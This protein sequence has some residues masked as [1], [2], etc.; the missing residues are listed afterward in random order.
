MH[1]T[2][3]RPIKLR[4]KDVSQPRLQ[5][6]LNE[7]HC[8]LILSFRTAAPDRNHQSSLFWPSKPLK[9]HPTPLAHWASLNFQPDAMASLL[10]PPDAVGNPMATP[11]A[12]QSGWATKKDWIKHQALIG[13]LY[14][15]QPLAEVMEFMES[16]HGF[17]A[18]LVTQLLVVLVL[19]LTSF[20]V[21]MYKTRVK[22]WGLD[23]KSKENE[24][25]AI[26]RKKKQ[27]GDQGKRIT[28]RVRNRSVDY[29]DV[30]RYWERKGVS[31][32]DVI[33]QRAESKTPEAVDCFTSPAS[34]IMMPES[35]VIPE[36]ILVSIRDYCKG[37]FE[38]RTWLATPDGNCTTTKVQGDPVV[39]LNALS[40]HCETA[41]A[42]FANSHFQEAGQSL[43]SATSEIK[44][45]LSAEHPLTLTCLFEIGATLFH[46]RRHEIALAIL[47]QFSALAEILVGERHPLRFICGW[48]A[49]MH[50]S[51]CEDIIIRCSRS[52]GDHF[53][54]LVGPMNWP[55][56]ISRLFIQLVDVGHDLSHKTF[57]LQGLLHQCQATLGS[58]DFRTCETR[59]SLAYHFIMKRD[60]VKAVRLGWDIVAHAQRPECLEFGVGHYAAGLWIVATSH[61]AMG[62]TFSAELYLRE[63][64]D[65]LVSESGPHDGQARIWLL[66][67]EDWL[68]EQGQLGSAAQV[69][70]RWKKSL[71]DSTDDS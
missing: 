34:P 33:A 7:P 12:N 20:R 53:E 17:R 13:Q 25:R 57:L 27:L 60:Y 69:Q 54:N 18:T 64:I 44:R 31:I 43:L 38:N 58:L 40:K 14:K 45:I 5:F 21:K 47:R 37:S 36:R 22:Q 19:L 3:V 2:F 32:D 6:A 49:L 4:E 51:Q 46:A 9:L 61:Y 63:A 28:F 24:M 1:G 52:I 15:E 55:T 67:L 70:A 68:R 48:L 16:Q 71:Q 66:T 62:E 56:L 10:E 8:P 65:V 23:K 39:H 59:L 42:L 35:M 30:V 11:N 41:R 29:K 26:V 50:P